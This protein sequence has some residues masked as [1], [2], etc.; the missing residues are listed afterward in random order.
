MQDINSFT[1]NYNKD[2]VSIKKYVK[3]VFFI[4]MWVGYKPIKLKQKLLINSNVKAK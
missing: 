2:Y 4:K 3:I 1:L